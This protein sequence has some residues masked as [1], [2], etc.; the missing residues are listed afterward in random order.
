VADALRQ[1]IAEG[2]LKPG[3]R[4]PSIRQ[5]AERFQVAAGTIQSA[6]RELKT[7]GL[8]VSQQAKGTYVR[9]GG[10]DARFARDS[11]QMKAEVAR[12][13][14]LSTE[15]AKLNE[16]LKD[17]IY[18]PSY[19]MKMIR[20]SDELRTR[21]LRMGALAAIESGTAMPTEP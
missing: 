15:L 17:G 10:T 3:E 21:T 19:L 16:P 13:R 2:K 5:L 4:L 12:I 14:E 1:E 20:L 8:V 6:L 11:P 18:T 9:S 7:E